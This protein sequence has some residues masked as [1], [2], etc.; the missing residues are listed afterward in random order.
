[1]NKSENMFFRIL[2]IFAHFVLLN[3]LWIICCL[4][5]ITI[6]PATTALYMVVKRWITESTDAG[7]VRLFF[8]SF[9]E[10]FKKS[11]V[12]GLFWLLAGAILYFD[13]TILL[14]VEFTGSFFILILLIFTAI[15]YIFVSIYT[16]FMLVQYEL[17]ISSILKNALLLSVSHLHYTLLFLVI[18]I[19]TLLMTYYIKIFLLIFGSVLAFI[20][21]H[22]FQK[23][24]HTKKLKGMSE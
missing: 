19:G 10:S 22:V 2:D 8:T 23:L 13:L 24:D 5:I 16:F 15:L 6:F 17:S 14:Q 9:K 1:M 11:F 20:L 4:P 3:A 21:Y 18:I 12:I 7:V